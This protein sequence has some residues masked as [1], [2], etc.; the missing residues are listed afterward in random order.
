LLSALGVPWKTVRDD[1]LLSNKYRKEEVVRRID[2]LKKLAR[3]NHDITDHEQNDRNIDA[4]YILQAEYID[5]ALDEAVKN[6]GSM[7]NFIRDGLGISDEEVA[8][9]KSALLE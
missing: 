8:R 6:Y 9:L 3:T 7:E 2:E 1:Y 5:A 4:F